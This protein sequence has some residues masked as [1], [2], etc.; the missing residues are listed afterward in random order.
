MTYLTQTN[1]PKKKDFL[2]K[3][4]SAILIIFFVIFSFN[5]FS[6]KILDVSDN[7]ESSFICTIPIFKTK[8]TFINENLI[9]K[10]KVESLDAEKISFEETKKENERLRELLNLTDDRDMAVG[11]VLR[12][13][14]SI[15]PLGDLM[16]KVSDSVN[17]NNIVYYNVGTSLVGLGRVIEINEDIARISLFSSPGEEF[18]ALIG[19]PQFETAVKGVGRNSF[20]AF[21]P[22]GVEINEGDIAI[23]PDISR[24]PIGKVISVDSE[25]S[26]AFYRVLFSILIN[27]NY[28]DFVLISKDVY[29]PSK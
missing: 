27:P 25:S 6:K 23:L 10:K 11:E 4:F 28:I 7:F 2:I 29:V 9:L 17:I 21:V 12:R 24:H 14:G 15:T 26:D 22:K 8:N 20:E 19:E 5:F 3:I 13:P 1:K 16:V 18:R